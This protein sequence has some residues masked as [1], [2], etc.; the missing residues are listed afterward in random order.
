MARSSAVQASSSRQQE[1]RLAI[2]CCFHRLSIVE[3]AP[4]PHHCF[5]FIDI[6]VQHFM[7]F[8]PVH[9][10]FVLLLA[11]IV[12]TAC[13][14]FTDTST[15]YSASM[16]GRIT[17]CHIKLK[18]V[19]MCMQLFYFSTQRAVMLFQGIKISCVHIVMIFQYVETLQFC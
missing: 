9:K 5:L 6:V 14:L 13:Q 1:R 11:H 17:E 2:V 10:P 8:H 16:W 7:D 15:I 3:I 4:S 12:P 19:C 18:H